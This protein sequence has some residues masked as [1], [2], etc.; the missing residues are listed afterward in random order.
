MIDYAQ[1]FLTSEECAAEV[2]RHYRA[3]LAEFFGSCFI[4]AGLA[5]WIFLTFAM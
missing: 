5:A 3:R 1:R 4:F 2:R